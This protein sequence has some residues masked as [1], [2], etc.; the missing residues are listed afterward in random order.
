MSLLELIGQTTSKGRVGNG[1]R[2]LATG[3]R[4]G[5]LYTA[6]YRLAMGME[7]KIFLASHGSASTPINFNAVA[8]YATTKPMLTIDVPAGTT[9]IPISI[10]V[11]FETA[12]GTLTECFAV[13]GTGNVGAGTSTVVTPACTRLASGATTGCTAYGTHTGAGSAPG[14]A[15]EFW[16]DGHPVAVVAGV[17][18]K[19][20]YDIDRHGPVVIGCG[21]TGCLAIYAQAVTSA[22]GYIKAQWIE[23]LSTEV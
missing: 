20:E 6:N 17:P 1:Q 21:A 12:V 11:F 2:L 14:S 10:Q 23:L 16:R 7:G 22:T 15:R 9:I 5:A 8:D 18:T 4:D 19:F 3:T 13:A